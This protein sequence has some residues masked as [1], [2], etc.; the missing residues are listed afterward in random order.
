MNG[1]AIL[2]RATFEKAV[3]LLKRYLFNTVMMVVG[4]YLLF[5]L[6]FFGGRMMAP[7]VVSDSTEAL[8]VGY[9][10][11]M[12]AVRA[13]QQTSSDVTREAQ[14]GTLEQLHLSPYGIGRVVLFT[15]VVNVLVT[16]LIGGV[17]LGS[18]VVTTRTALA[19]DLVTIVPVAVLTILPVVGVGLCFGGLALLY[20]RVGQAASL[21]QLG[22]IVF[23]AM[24]LDAHPLLRFVPLSL[25][26]ALLEEAMATG[27][28]LWE[29]PVPDL[30]T[31]LAVAVLYLGG[32]YLV[33][34]A[35][36]TRAR[37]RGV[38]GHY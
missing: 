36:A 6:L 9:L 35:L 32:G 7:T 27:T 24:P 28:R 18:M 17:I 26:T 19:I 37:K 29:F 20:K 16:L 30:L 23:L 14:W 33:F 31:L 2:F 10:V 1:H 25:G 12:M 13:Y 15:S 3:W 4:M 22:F 8:V 21:M 11:W 38:L 34:K 5:A